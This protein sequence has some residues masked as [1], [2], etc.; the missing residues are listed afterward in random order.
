MADLHS[1]SAAAAEE[2]D[3]KQLAVSDVEAGKADTALTDTL[4][5]ATEVH[6]ELSSWWESQNNPLSGAFWKYHFGTDMLIAS[7]FF[8]ASSVL[9]VAMEVDAIM[10]DPDTN[11]DITVSYY[12]GFAVSILYLFGSVYFVW[13]SYPEEMARMEKQIAT[14]DASTL[15]FSERYFTGSDMLI[16]TWFFL[17]CGFPYLVYAFFMMFHCPT[18]WIGWV[19]FLGCG[20]YAAVLAVWVIAAMPENL[21]QNGGAG[22]TYFMDRCIRPLC[23]LCWEDGN[24]TDLFFRRHVG[25]DMMAGTWLFFIFAMLLVPYA[26]YMCIVEPDDSYSWL[27]MGSNAGFAF[28]AAVMVYTMYPE[29]VGSSAVWNLC[30]CSR[31]H[32]MDL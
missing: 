13:L 4:H 3:T 18:N 10:E 16:A 1:S 2:S 21:Q 5:A 20:V 23:C 7:W 24:S 27:T 12:C 9:F 31:A 29:H 28:G 11:T 15:T 19:A 8:L 6:E 30:T 17:A 32:L 26:F 14:E 22:S 25:N